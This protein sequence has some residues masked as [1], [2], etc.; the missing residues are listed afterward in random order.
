M[1]KFMKDLRKLCY[2]LPFFLSALVAQL[3][4]AFDC[5]SKGQGFEF[6]RAH[7]D[8]SKNDK[9][10]LSKNLCFYLINKRR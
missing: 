5:G 7:H 4:R 3:D 8:I 9:I 1:A 2:T 6:L 10:L